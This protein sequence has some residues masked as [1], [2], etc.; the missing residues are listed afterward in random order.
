MTQFPRIFLLIAILVTGGWAQA[1]NTYRGYWVTQFFTPV[2]TPSGIKRQKMLL[3]IQ[4]VAGS[5][6]LFRV[7]YYLWTKGFDQV[8]GP[9]FENGVLDGETGWLYLGKGK[10]G[11]DIIKLENGRMFFFL[12]NNPTGAS[13]PSILNMTK[14]DDATGL[15]L[16][17]II[18]KKK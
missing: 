18:K 2:N 11:R 10:D 1:Q 14:V 4:P 3:N 13:K 12:K 15:Q 6:E 17:A 7:Y 8:S 16:E 5:S 9:Q